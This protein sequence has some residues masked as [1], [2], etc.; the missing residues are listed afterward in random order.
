M[1][2]VAVWLL[3]LKWSFRRTRAGTLRSE[4]QAHEF[5]FL[6]LFDPG[7]DP[8]AGTTD[9]G[10]SGVIGMALSLS[11]FVLEQRTGVLRIASHGVLFGVEVSS[12]SS[13]VCLA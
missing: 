7:A 6:A 8:E 13:S 4:G 2:S 11:E 10:V 5:P 1:T 3:S 9:H 12:R